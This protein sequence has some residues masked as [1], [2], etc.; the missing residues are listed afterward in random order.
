MLEEFPEWFYCTKNNRLPLYT[1][2]CGRFSLGG[3]LTHYRS[4]P[5]GFLL[6]QYPVGGLF[7]LL[8]PVELS[9]KRQ[10]IAAMGPLLGTPESRIGV[11]SQ[12]RLPSSPE[13]RSSGDG[14]HSGWRMV[15]GL[16]TGYSRITDREP[17]DGMI[18][19]PGE[20]ASWSIMP[21]MPT[22]KIDS[23]HY[24]HPSHETRHEKRV[25]DWLTTLTLN[26]RATMDPFR[27]HQLLVLSCPPAPIEKR[28]FSMEPIGI[29]N[30]WMTVAF[31]SLCRG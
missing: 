31:S 27:I 13:W 18:I 11:T 1:T 2:G 26:H 16:E 20:K 25:A 12:Q 22:E 28:V 17:G 29:G 24:K 10:D 7:Q 15:L 3:V 14:A 4:E 21:P 8:H 5:T 30:T 6:I 23:P 19:P 9:S